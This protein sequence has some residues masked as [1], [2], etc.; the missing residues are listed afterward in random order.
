MLRA[1]VPGIKG[2]VY[3]FAGRK[4]CQIPYRTILDIRFLNAE[5]NSFSCFAVQ[6]LYQI[7][8]PKVLQEEGGKKQGV[9]SGMMSVI[10]TKQPER[11][12]VAGHP[13]IKRI[14]DKSLGD[15]FFSA[16]NDILPDQVDIVMKLQGKIILKDNST[17]VDHVFDPFLGK[18]VETCFEGYIPTISKIGRQVTAK[19][20]IPHLLGSSAEEIVYNERSVQTAP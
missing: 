9:L 11:F 13:T 18:R 19:A 16:L 1:A 7:G 10:M 2:P 4:F 3:E 14:Y 20:I 5:T 15:L 12:T 8:A 6:S 17:K